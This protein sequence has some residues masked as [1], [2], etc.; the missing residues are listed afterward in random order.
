M[1]VWECKVVLTDDAELPDGA[2]LPMRQ[3]VKQACRELCGQEPNTVFSGWGG[4][5]TE[6]EKRALTS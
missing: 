6:G 5:L 4:K 3:A 2:D 1:K